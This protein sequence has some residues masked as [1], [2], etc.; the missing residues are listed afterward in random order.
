MPTMWGPSSWEAKNRRMEVYFVD[1]GKGTS[2]LILLGENRAIIIDCGQRS[3]ALIQLLARFD[4]QKIVCL[5]LSHNHIDHIGGAL[6]V[7]TAYERRIEKICFL[8]DGELHPTK[9]WQKIKEQLRDGILTYNDLVRL[10]CEGQ[11]RMLFEERARRLSLKILSPRF[12]DNLQAVEETKPNATSGVL[13]L[14]I[15]E[16]RIVFA[17]D[18]TIRQWQRIRELRGKPL[19]CDILAVP[20]HAGIVWNSP[21]DLQ[22][23]YEEGV[24]PRYAIV[25]V[26]TSNSDR[27]PRPEVIKAITSTGARVVC[28][29]ITAR[30][31]DKLE[32][33]R[34][35]VLPPIVPGV[36]KPTSD[37]TGAGNSRNVACGGTMVAEFENSILNLHR[38]REHQTAID[39]L[40][41][42]PG[43]HP[44]CR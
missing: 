18:S 43:G 19:E 30:C 21:K 2:N 29:Q 23:L 25:S 31:F 27:H 38:L 36:S 28:T 7:L 8:E 33:I 12:T 32:Q 13:L 37:L 9:I 15:E 20:H 4:V 41:T 39:R 5:I 44:L 16:K 10:E 6:S 26:A 11:P 42:I 22:W 1:I 34:P 24:R 14:T 35:G 3:D 17:S 40:A